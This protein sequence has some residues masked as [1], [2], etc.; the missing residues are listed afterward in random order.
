MTEI[1]PR[2]YFADS[3]GRTIENGKIY[4]GEANK[5]PQTFPIQAYWDVAL[6]VPAAQPVMVSG[7]Y[8]LN[9]GSRADLFVSE[10]SFSVRI[11]DRND[12][13]VDYIAS[14]PNGLLAPGGSASVGFLQSGTGAVERTV[15][16]K[17]RE[18]N[19]LT[20]FATGDGVTDDTVQITAA[21]VGRSGKIIW[22]NG[23]T[24]VV[25]NLTIPSGTIMQ[26][27]GTI[28]RKTGSVGY[29][30]KGTDAT[31]VQLLDV[32][33]DGNN[34]GDVKQL[35]R[36]DG[37]SHDLVVEGCTFKNSTLDGLALAGTCARAKIINNRAYSN[38]NRGV[39]VST[40]GDGGHTISGN[41]CRLNGASGILVSAPHATVIGNDCFSN[42]Q[43]VTM[44][45]GILI[46][47]SDYPQAIG[48]RCVDNGTGA[49]FNHGI[50]FNTCA[51]GVMQGNTSIGNNGS[52]LDAYISSGTTITG[53]QSLNNNLRGI[54][55]D[56]GARYTTC[57]G[58]VVQSNKEVGIS[59]YNAVGAT[60]ADNI[61]TANGTL[62]TAVNPLLGTANSPYG[63][64]LWGA[65]NYANF[66]RV[67]GNVIS[68]N[69]GSGANGVGLYIDPSCVSVTLSD[70][71]FT[72]NTVQATLVAGNL[73]FASKNVGLYFDQSGG[74]TIASGSTSIAVV[75]ANTMSFTP[76]PGD[77]TLTA[78]NSPTTA[79][80]EIY[81]TSVTAAGF[82]IN[83][84]TNPGASGF[85]VAWR[86]RREAF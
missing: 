50:Q 26:G 65:G 49:L 66:A 30:I 8:A 64:A 33:F 59:V 76:V 20:D 42:G 39:V 23:L 55:I 53:N 45:A 62:G 79:P 73:V 85:V 13:Q 10:G 6:T 1:Y 82:T 46:I 75:F 5:D 81:P 36:F 52:G 74:A 80:G 3:G 29:M 34:V 86:C 51:N 22:L 14:V 68:G 15:Q 77:I 4:L 19:S 54:E 43:T 83:C 67:T 61:V 48:N 47:T 60:L 57:V 18:T 11:R 12:A 78:A 37:A 41:W 38:A 63:I 28:K 35:V 24:Y 84:R 2:N 58:N 69:V 40:T 16:T 9:A 7:G 27:P 56:S 17:L 25:S 21:W 71:L 72:A 31:D 44:E 32:T 70:N